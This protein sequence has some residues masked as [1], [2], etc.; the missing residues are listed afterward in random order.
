MSPYKIAKAYVVYYAIE[1]VGESQR[2]IR[3]EEEACVKSGQIL[4]YF[5]KNKYEY[6]SRKLCSFTQNHS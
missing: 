2:P 3:H 4:Y 1:S 6:D 5:V